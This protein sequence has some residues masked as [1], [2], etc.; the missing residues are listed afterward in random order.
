MDLKQYDL[1][2]ICETGHEFQLIA[3]GTRELTDLKVTVRGGDSK[4][5]KQWTRGQFMKRQQKAALVRRGAKQ[6]EISLEEAE[7]FAAQ[8]AAQ[9]VIS[10]KNFEENGKP[11]ESTPENI[12][13]IMRKYD[14]I[15]D[16]VVE[17]SDFLPNF[18]VTPQKTQ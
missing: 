9:R 4:T 14:W 7:E 2:E 17:E 18:T 12:L 8:S 15:R 13:H 6:E 10:I 5:V 3:P 1:A 16:Q 11:L